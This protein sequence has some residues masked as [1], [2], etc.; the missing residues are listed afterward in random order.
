MDAIVHVFYEVAG[1]AGAF[2]SSAA[3]SRFGNNYSFFMSPVFM[4][5]AAGIWIWISALSFS[6]KPAH[7]AVQGDVALAEVERQGMRSN[8]YFVA[9]YRGFIIFFK[10][11]Y[12]GGRLIF[13]HRG[14]I[15]L[16]PA[17]SLALYLHRF[18][19]S[20]LAQ[21]MLVVS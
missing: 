12:F 16:F 9:V 15:W 14:F 20:S 11:V 8:N 2:S 18:L 3:I 4:A 17:Y 7:G 1:T 21:H 10:S 6:K 13:G 19:E 5:M